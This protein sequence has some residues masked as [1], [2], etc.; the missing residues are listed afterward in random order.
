MIIP[1]VL[2]KYEEYLNS[3]I[4]TINKISFRRQQTLPWESKC[5]GCPYLETM[6]DYPV[7]ENGKPMMFLA[8]INLDEMPALEEFP[9]TGILQFY[10]MDDDYYGYDGKCKVI[11]IPE[12]KKDVQINKNPYEDKYIG[13][14]PFEYEGKMIFTYEKMFIGTE[15]GEFQDRF[16]HKVTDD[17]WNAL[18]DI[19]SP[20]GCHIGGY[21]LF[22]QET[23]EYYDDG[24]SD[25]LLLQ[26]DID[27]ECRI[28]FGD[29][30]N[31]V[32]LISKDDLRNRNFNNVAYDWQ[33]C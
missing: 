23:P 26:L 30:G 29:S 10:I 11:Y 1:K 15:C 4:K 24:S 19:C 5:G 31:C 32:F 27:D 21:P 33:C 22:V 2:L 8:Q 18:Y 14:K 20:S 6:D 16:R 12:Y 17:E 25:I 3:T 7:G 13:Y 28:M 9:T